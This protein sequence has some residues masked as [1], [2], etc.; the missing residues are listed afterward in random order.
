MIVQTEDSLQSA[1]L[2]IM[3][4]D[5][6]EK[7]H[8]WDRKLAHYLMTRN[9]PV[10]HVINKCDNLLR[11][12]VDEIDEEVHKLTGL[13]I[14]I[15]VSA[16]HKLNLGELS[17]AIHPFYV[18]HRLR[19]SIEER[20]RAQEAQE[21]VKPE[22]I[23]AEEDTTMRIALIGR[24]NVGKST[25]LN[26]LI[27]EERVVVSS[28]PGTTRDTIE[29]ATKYIHDGQ[30]YKILIADTAG[31]RKKKH[32]SGDRVQT[33]SHEDTMRTIKYA[34]VVC[35]LVDAQ[36]PLTAEDLDIAQLIEKE[37]RGMIIAANKWDV[38][39]EPYVI[40]NR[41][42]N[43]VHNALSQVK[44]L[45]VVVCSALTGKNL[46]LVIRK[47]I[48]CYRRWN[49]RIPTAK[50]N[51][52]MEKYLTTQSLPA[53][54]PKIQYVTQVSSRPPKFTVFFK[55]RETVLPRQFERQLLNAIRE[56][57]DL[58]GV[59]IRIVQRSRTKDKRKKEKMES[60]KK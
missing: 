21:D 13:G 26:K 1:H 58:G 27:G 17:R 38:V 7:L 44:G 45:S 60:K 59:P 23:T 4:T 24:A 2:A 56:E 48:E 55:G 43:T 33:L 3:V 10:I 15:F 52:F 12:G 40:A 6:R 31:L 57:F 22:E 53:Y 18:A 37:G 5:F 42:E 39:T 14:P 11:M 32:I 35:L 25:M 46:P 47:S 54:F 28:V 49:L 19:R 9:M 30:E 36:E 50:L 29:L 16:E 41:I 51:A 8:P 20:L 34:N